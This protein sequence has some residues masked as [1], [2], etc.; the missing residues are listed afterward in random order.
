MQYKNSRTSQIITHAVKYNYRLVTIASTYFSSTHK[1]NLF[2]NDYEYTYYYDHS[3][4]YRNPIRFDWP[5]P[6]ICYQAITFKNFA[7]RN[8]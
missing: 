8:S 3:C 2:E 5:H 7:I 4:F 6:A 1:Y